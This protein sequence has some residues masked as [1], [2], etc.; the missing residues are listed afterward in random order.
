MVVIHIYFVTRT[1]LRDIFYVIIYFIAVISKSL[2]YSSISPH[3]ISDYSFNGYYG[4]VLYIAYCYVSG[5][6]MVP[7]LSHGHSYV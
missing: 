3:V 2:G 5:C 6:Y 1:Q 7:V 4:I